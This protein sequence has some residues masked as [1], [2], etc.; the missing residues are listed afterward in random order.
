MVPRTD[1]GTAQALR[2]FRWKWVLISL[3]VGAAL[4]AILVEVARGDLP[5]TIEIPHTDTVITAGVLA[6]VLSGLLVGFA[7][8]GNT[9]AEAGVAGLC[10]A[11]F[12]EAVIVTLLDDIIFWWMPLGI[13]G[14]FVLALGGGWVGELLQ[15]TLEDR[16]GRRGRLQWPWIGAGVIIGVLLSSYFVLLGKALFG[17]DALG[18]L[19]GFSSSFLITGFFVG[20]FSPGITLLEP[21]LAGIGAIFVDAF[22]SGA[23][24]G[25]PFPVLAVLIAAVGA[26]VLSL[27]GGWI[28]EWTQMRWG[29]TRPA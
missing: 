11:I 23:G 24:L 8:P 12:C 26:F 14:G 15:G 2:A 27:V 17:L 10:L 29:S 19:L 6:F 25:A 21:A 9:I 20:V 3:A 5:H 16:S 28:G 18:I 1:S 22:V 4:V 13:V 7:S